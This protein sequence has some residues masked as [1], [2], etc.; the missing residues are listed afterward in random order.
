MLKHFDIINFLI[1][2]IFL[3]LLFC[4]QSHFISYQH[5]IQVIENNLI[6]LLTGPCFILGIFSYVNNEKPTASIK[7]SVQRHFLYF[8]ILSCYFMTI[9]KFDLN[10]VTH[11]KIYSSAPGLFLQKEQSVWLDLRFKNDKDK[12]TL[13]RNDL[14]SFEQDGYFLSGQIRALAQDQAYINIRDNESRIIASQIEMPVPENYMAIAAGAKGDQI[15]LVSVDKIKGKIH[16]SFSDF[17]N[18]M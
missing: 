18:E 10:L 13:K 17:L 7:L 2:A 3:V 9:Y 8:A 14:I 5:W 4:F 16:L 11:F 12:F 6:L 1:L 15:N